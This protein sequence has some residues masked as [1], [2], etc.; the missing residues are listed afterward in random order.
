V[1]AWLEI[2]VSFIFAL[3]GAASAYLVSKLKP[4]YWMLGYFVPLLLLLMIAL[5][6]HYRILA[7]IP[8]LSWVMGTRLEYA[9]LGFLATAVLT[10][11]LTRLSNIAWKTIAV[12]LAGI[13]IGFLSILPYYD[14][15]ECLDELKAI[16]TQIDENGVCSQHTGYTCGPASAV[17]ALHALGVESD[18]S[19]IAIAT[20]TCPTVG[21]P[22]RTLCTVLN[23]MYGQKGI[24]CEYRYFGDVV[25]LRNAVPALA[26][27]KFAFLC[28]HYV[29][30]LEVTDDSVIVGDP[31]LGRHSISH[32][33][34]AD[35]WRGTAIV[36]RRDKTQNSTEE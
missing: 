28:D 27:M 10:A 18:E 4:P 21:T 33:A 26:E 20:K 19:A 6:R 29:T 24:V 17:T 14:P 23:R 35:Q 34:F 16:P 9:F 30:V 32:R 22:P 1:P 25:E 5:A 7:F 12:T 15:V 31:L 8:P 13:A 2:A 36:L 3:S 11:P